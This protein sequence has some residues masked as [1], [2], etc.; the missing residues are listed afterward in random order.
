MTAAATILDRDELDRLEQAAFARL[1]RAGLVDRYSRDLYAPHS[2]ERAIVAE[3][4]AAVAEQLAAE[5][6]G[7]RDA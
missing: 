7:A 3:T 2:R 6:D 1:H 5:G 4:V